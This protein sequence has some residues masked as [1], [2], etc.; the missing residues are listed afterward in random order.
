MKKIIPLLVLAIF[1]F[2]GCSR[3]MDDIINEE[4]S[5]TGIVES[6]ENN[7]IVVSID[8]TDDL[9]EKYKSIKVS[10]NAEMEDSIKD[11][12]ECDEVKVYYKGVKEGKLAEVETVFAITLLT[13]VER[14]EL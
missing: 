6:V 13:P 1:V 2:A 10:L 14:G 3:T 9:Y 4:L 7:H 8:E 12:N 5:F 11:L